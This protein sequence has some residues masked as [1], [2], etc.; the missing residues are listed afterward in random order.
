MKHLTRN[1]LLILVLIIIFIIVKA[2]FYGD[3][4]SFGTVP[5]VVTLVAVG[6]VIWA[7]WVY[8]TQKR[9][10]KSNKEIDRSALAK[11]GISKQEYC[12]AQGLAYGVEEDKI[13]KNLKLDDQEYQKLVRSLHEKLNAS[14]VEGV[15]AEAKARHIVYF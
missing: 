15:V 12:V 14:N 4:F 1:A 5:V 10:H 6:L 8:S 7:I 13:K 11:L 3:G 2:F 9:S